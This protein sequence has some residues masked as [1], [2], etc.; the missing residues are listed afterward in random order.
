[1]ALEVLP[2]VCP[3]NKNPDSFVIEDQAYVGDGKIIN[4]NF[5]NGLSIESAKSKVIDLLSDK[6]Q[7]QPKVTYRLKDW[8]ISRQR[9]WGCPIPIIHCNKCGIVPEKKEH[10]PVKLPET[11]LSKHQEILYL[12]AEKL[13]EY[14]LSKMWRTRRARNR[15]NGYVRRQL[16]VFHKVH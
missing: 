16:L 15:Y 9:Y 14:V 10:L 5:L 4:S 13:A 7:G 1:M 11:F 8:G 6:K 12:T 2:V 3:A